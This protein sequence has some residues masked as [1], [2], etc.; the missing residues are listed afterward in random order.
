MGERST[1]QPTTKGMTSQA[2]LAATTTPGRGVA[3]TPQI[4]SERMMK[5]LVKRTAPQITAGMRI[6]SRPFAKA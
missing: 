3:C 1:R 2:R 5:T 6:Q 4:S